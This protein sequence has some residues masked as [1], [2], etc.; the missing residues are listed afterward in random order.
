MKQLEADVC[1]IGSGVAGAIVAGECIRAGRSVLMLEAGRRVSGR[2]L[3]LRFAEMLIRDYR[4]PRMSLWHRKSRYNKT[5][6]SST[7]NR[8]YRLPGLAVVAR[9]GSTLGW[10]GDAYRLRPEDFR[11]NSLTGQ[12][13]DWPLSYDTLEPW[14][15]KAE[16]ILRVSGDQSDQGHPPRSE[17]FPQPARA[18]HTRDRQFLD[19][20]AEQGWPGMHHNFSLAADG[21]AFAADE[22]LDQLETNSNFR[23]LTQCV[24]KRILCSSRQRANA[25]EF[26]DFANQRQ[27]TSGFQ[28]VVV[29]CGGIE[30]PN[31]L[32]NSANN[33][34]PDGLG[35]HSGHLGRHL[36]SHSGIALG[37]RPRGFRWRNGPIAP[38]ASTRQ[39]D[40][41]G[42]QASGKYIL[43]W[44]PAPTGYIFVNAMLEQF[45]NEHNCV[46][47]GTG[48]TRFGTQ[49][50]TIAYND[51]ER[52]QTKISA[53]E[54]QLEAFAE[55]M[56]LDVSVRRHFVH[57]HPMC[58]S[59]MSEQEGDGVID[60]NLRVHTMDNVHVCSSA[61]FSTGGAANPTVTI[62]A[63][64][65][66]LGAYLGRHKT[67]TNGQH[68]DVTR[69]PQNAMLHRPTRTEDG[70]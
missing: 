55:Q 47:P 9:G 27:L 20:L 19:F 41:E 13:L 63:L 36:I 60:A 25:V 62:A 42:M 26:Y 1:V 28:T 45:P 33:W 66:R 8:T 2:A 48:K 24:A 43:I 54:K 23:I 68:I 12:G 39:F 49:A 69:S 3:L 67:F 5:D 30:T 7:G 4:I 11:L 10:S 52:Q 22:L 44:R 21:G 35:N 61:G 38:T 32:H 51:D 65:G 17:P 64:A 29:C 16:Q 59:R 15:T 58:T 37:G 40:T 50:P 56:A 34:W 53:V 6:Y 57:A 18:F 46:T 14:Y 70:Q 31:L